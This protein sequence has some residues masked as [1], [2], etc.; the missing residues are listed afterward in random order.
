MPYDQTHKERVRAKIVESARVLFNR[1]GFAGVSIDDIMAEAGLTRGGFY[2]H[3]TNKEELYAEAV[4]S[5][6]EGMACRCEAYTGRA[7]DGAGL[8]LAEHIVE[9]YLSAGHLG[10]LDG[11]CPMIALPSDVARAGPKV[12]EAYQMLLL[13]LAGTFERN[14]QGPDRG[15]RERAL[16]LTALCIGGMVLARTIPDSEIADEIREV[17]RRKALATLGE[18]RAA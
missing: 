14:L 2:N 16:T 15:A 5:F 8:K 9:A 18:Q 7:L 4:A 6:L 3:F 11:Q 1:H 17:A 10:D 12:R 13:A